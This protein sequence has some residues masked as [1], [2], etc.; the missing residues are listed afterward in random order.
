RAAQRCSRIAKDRMIECIEGLGAQGYSQRLM[1]P[2]LPLERAIKGNQSRAAV[3]VLP[4]IAE[5]ST[6][7]LHKGAGIEP[8]AACT[9]T[10]KLLKRT[11]LVGYLAVAG[12]IQL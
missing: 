11:H 10:M 5:H 3:D 4:H 9:D 2:D 1:Q 12:G 7:R 8:G 6:G